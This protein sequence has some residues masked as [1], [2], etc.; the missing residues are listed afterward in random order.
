[1]QKGWLLLSLAVATGV[2]WRSDLSH[3][4]W[5]QLIQFA[6]YC[7]LAAVDKHERYV[8]T[9][10]TQAVL[11]I[12]GVIAMSAANC[13]VLTDAADEWG[14]EY[15]V[16]NFA[17]H[18]APLLIVYAAPSTKPP[19]QPDLQVVQGMAWFL[20]YI[21]HHNGPSVYGCDMPS[22]PIVVSALIIALVLCVPAV[23]DEVCEAFTQKRQRAIQAEVYRIVA[24]TIGL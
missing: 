17:V 4:T 7:G 14:A 6:F 1:M 13:S 20:V 9:F 8:L 19:H 11:T 2:L 23:L 24:F 5:W 10:A 18:Y 12:V 16:L 22:W 3:F 21:S 15:V